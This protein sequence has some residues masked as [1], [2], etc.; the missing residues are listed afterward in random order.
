MKSPGTCVKTN[1]YI[2][3]LF[4]I[5]CILDEEGPANQRSVKLQ[6]KTNFVW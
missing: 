5:D 3:F 2:Y 1:K 4:S 6:F